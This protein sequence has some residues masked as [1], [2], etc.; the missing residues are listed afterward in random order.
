MKL[1]VEKQ[2]MLKWEDVPVLLCAILQELRVM[3]GK[4]AMP[5]TTKEVVIEP[6]TE[7]PQTVET[8]KQEEPANA[9]TGITHDE[10]KGLCLD[11]NRKNPANKD[12]ITGIIAEFTDGKLADVP[13]A[14]LPEL[15]ARIDSLNG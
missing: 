4:P 3:N 6:K 1:D 8:E 11:L 10:V 12:K 7:E 14:K 13:S 15:K 2:E 9:E 5:K